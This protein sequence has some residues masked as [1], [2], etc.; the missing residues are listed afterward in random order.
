[1]KITEFLDKTNLD[2]TLLI[3][4][5]GGG[6]YG[7]ELLLEVLQNLLAQKKVKQLTVAYQ[8]PSL[9]GRMHHDFGNRLVQVHSRIALL[10]A[11]RRSKNI[12][13]GGGGLW[14]VDMNSNTF[15]MSMYLFFCRF[16]L[17]KNVYLI[18]VGY[19]SSTTRLGHIGAWFAAKAA[20]LIIVR[21]AESERNFRRSNKRTYRDQDMAF[22][23][24]KITPATYK[25]DVAALEKKLPIKDK[26]LF[27]T[28]R[29]FRHGNHFSEYVER[30]IKERP[31]LTVIVGLLELEAADSESYAVARRWQRTYPNVR[32]LD[33]AFNPL[34]LF[35]Y[36]QRY[37]DKLVLVGPQFHIIITAYLAGVKFMPITY[38]N[39]VGEL[40]RQINQSN[41]LPIQDMTEADL[42]RFVR[43]AFGGKA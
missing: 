2:N 9:Y 3:G 8:R 14:G 22:Y 40:Y 16:I 4:Y 28:L 30:L 7:D 19:Y 21:D 29:R 17:R 39:K 34:G 24:K 10:T 11:T 31:D 12:L 42:R 38:D 6:N 37:K 32:L 27:V 43:T 36:F 5:Y 13:I 15:F 18:G 41:V 26:A 20:R 33:S 23:A 1:M 35:F 25:A